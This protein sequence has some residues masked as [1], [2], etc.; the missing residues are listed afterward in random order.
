[1]N[2]YAEQLNLLKEDID[3]QETDTVT[4]AAEMIENPLEETN[5]TILKDIQK[6]KRKV[7]QKVLKLIKEI[8][9]KSKYYNK[10]QIES[11]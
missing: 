1:M 6:K 11:K 3:R 8:Q 4:I 2:F 9:S 7:N 5:I 10:N